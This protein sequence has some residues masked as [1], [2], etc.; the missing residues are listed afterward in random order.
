MILILQNFTPI[1][2][3]YSHFLFRK[4]YRYV[5]FQACGLGPSEISS[6]SKMLSRKFRFKEGEEDAG[7]EDA[8]K[9]ESFK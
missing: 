5:E 8:G 1:S 7:K 6:R 9:E 2:L 4:I 3:Y